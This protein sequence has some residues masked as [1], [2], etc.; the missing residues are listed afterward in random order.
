MRGDTKP[1]CVF[2]TNHA[3]VLICIAQDPQ[4]RVRDIGDLV[5]ITERAAHRIVT[6]LAA[7]GYITKRRAGRRNR[8]TVHS[9]PPRV[10]PLVSSDRAAHLMAVLTRQTA[11]DSRELTPF[12]AFSDKS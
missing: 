4:V 8:Y 2:L 6:D 9:H 10:D 5:G 7:G 12:V 1:S 11:E 3:R